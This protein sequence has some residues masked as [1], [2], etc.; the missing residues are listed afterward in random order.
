MP[1]A[2]RRLVRHKDS[3]VLELWRHRGRIDSG[4]LLRGIEYQGLIQLKLVVTLST[5]ATAIRLLIVSCW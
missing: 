5:S 3:Y 1:K 4:T 2:D